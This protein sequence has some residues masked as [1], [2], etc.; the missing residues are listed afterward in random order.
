MKEM[1]GYVRVTLDKLQSIQTEMV[2]NDNSWHDWKFQ[3]LVE[4]LEKWTV[5]NPIPLSDKRNSEKSN[6]NSKSYQPK[7]TKSECVYCE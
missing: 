1:H 5:R 6:G 4:A 7:Q 3:Q 2:R